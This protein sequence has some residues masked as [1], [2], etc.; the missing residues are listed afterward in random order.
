MSTKFTARNVFNIGVDSFWEKIFFNPEYNERMYMQVLKFKA[1]K[2]LEQKDMG[3]G[4]I[5]RRIHVEPSS[6]VPGALQKLIGDGISYT[7]EGNFNAATKRWTYRT[8]TSKMADK[9]T[10]KGE[11]FVEPKGEKQ[12]ERVISCDINCSI[13]GL[14]GMVEGFIE[15]QTK[16]SY[17][18]VARFTNEFIAEKKLNG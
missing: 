10:V 11:Y 9:L 4:N 15:K 16:E 2:V 8:I 3:G 5:M 18:V 6:S 1:F 13:F 14:G 12:L 7:E 17:E